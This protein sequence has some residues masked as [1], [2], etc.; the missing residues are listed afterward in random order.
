MDKSIAAAF[1]TV[2]LS[3][4]SVKRFET[5]RVIKGPIL[6]DILETTL[7][8]P[9][10]FNLQP[11]QVILV[12]SEENK[13]VL[14]EH[15]ML[16]IGNQY[17]TRDAS[18]VA[19]FLADLQL[20][21]RIE[22][23]EKLERDS[24]FYRD[25]NYLSVLPLASSFM[26]GEGHAATFLK[27]SATA[28]LSEIQPMPTIEPV[29]AWSNKNVA[30]MAQTFVLAATSHRLATCI[31]EG[32]DARRVRDILGV[33]QDRYAVPLMVA[34]GYEYKEEEDDNTTLTPR[35][36]LEEVVFDEY[37]GQIRKDW[38][39]QPGDEDK[40]EDSPLSNAS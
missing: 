5:D 28:A 17:R 15:A 25:S 16:G 22:R 3:R 40:E 38:K 31:M 26:V 37:F 12:Q 34:M 24:P 33:P 32:F 39:T 27:Q 2:A 21:K 7:R 1:R 20:G 11:A 18:V 19:V 35:L 36:H 30:L 4:R 29:W 14:S 9:S 13:K 8:S 10:S 6:Q 23:I